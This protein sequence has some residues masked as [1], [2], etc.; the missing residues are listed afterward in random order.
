MSLVNAYFFYH[1]LK[2]IA[3]YL[4]KNQSDFLYIQH[5]KSRP[6]TVVKVS[7]TKQ[8]RLREILIINISKKKKVDF[9]TPRIEIALKTSRIKISQAFWADAVY[10]LPIFVWIWGAPYLLLSL[11]AIY[12]FFLGA[13]RFF[14]TRCIT[15]K[16]A[17]WHFHFFPNIETKFVLSSTT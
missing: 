17:Y 9:D 4:Y 1:T 15:L 13:I 8:Q 3:K 6:Y 7:T 12:L 10:I 14:T 2:H 5:C 11:R 16:L